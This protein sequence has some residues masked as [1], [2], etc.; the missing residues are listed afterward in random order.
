MHYRTT[1]W[2][3][4]VDVDTLNVKLRK[5]GAERLRH[6]MKPDEAIGAIFTF[7]GVLADTHELQVRSWEIVA[8]EEGLPMPSIPRPQMFDLPAERAITEVQ[9]GIHCRAS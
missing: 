9:P 8:E 1:G 3:E 5:R 6:A 7:D 4:Q 2:V